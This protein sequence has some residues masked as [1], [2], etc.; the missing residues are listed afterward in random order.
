V[1]GARLLVVED[2][3]TTRTAVA[4]NLAGHGY[5][6]QQA[7][8]AAGALRQWEGAR[9]DAIILDLGLPD[10]DGMTVIRRVR[11]DAATPILVLSAR[12]QEAD[13]VAALEAGADDYVTKPFGMAELRARIVALIRRAVGP[14]GEPTGV[15]RNG[16]ITLDATRRLVTVS[17]HELSLTPREYEL[18]RVML[19]S[20]GRVLTRGRLLRAVW[21]TA[22]T[23]EGHYLHVYVSRLRRK[24]AEADPDGDARDLVT[25]EPG[26][27]YR[28][29]DDPDAAA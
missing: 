1:S 23:E 9:P 21:G 7:P 4:A 14:A 3:E 6:V 22:Y 26:I 20:P 16:S 25:A 8:D 18:L 15:L 27:G 19:A 12:G 29:R 11:R 10:L 13:K 17:E 28:V 24:L 2:D 5:Q